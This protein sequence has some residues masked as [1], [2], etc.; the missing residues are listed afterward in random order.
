[1][2]ALRSLE[3]R[4]DHPYLLRLY[5][6]SEAEFEALADEDLKAEYLDGV[7]IVHSPA[8]FSHE[9]R[10]AFLLALLRLYAETHGIG[11]V[12]GGNALFRVGRRQFAPD[13]MVL[14][15]HVP[16]V[17]QRAEGIPLLVVEVLSESTRDYDLGEKRRLYREAGV[18]E[19]WLVDVEGQVVIVERRGRGYESEEIHEGWVVSEAVPG[20]R[21]RAE[22][23]WQEPLPSILECWQALSSAG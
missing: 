4:S 22:W 1:M 12:V 11:R 10:Q 14:P 2:Q 9:D 7:M 16:I 15:R 13:V 3:V 19:L 20:F 6:V 21:I 23:L 5:G 17:R 18:G 8:G